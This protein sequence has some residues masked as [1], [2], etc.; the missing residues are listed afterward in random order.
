MPTTFWLSVNYVTICAFKGFMEIDTASNNS[1]KEELWANA[2]STQ[3][4][5][6]ILQYV[7]ADNYPNR[8]NG[9]STEMCISRIEIATKLTV[10]WADFPSNSSKLSNWV[11]GEKTA[12]WDATSSCYTDYTDCYEAVCKSYLVDLS[13]LKY[14][15]R[16]FLVKCQT[17]IYV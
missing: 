8:P 4:W 17:F 2:Q 12:K 9:F 1:L 5:W 15:S 3:Y 7:R 14:T 10:K 6:K 16:S 13:R 11:T